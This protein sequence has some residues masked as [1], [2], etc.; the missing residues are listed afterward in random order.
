MSKNCVCHP[1]ILTFAI[2]LHFTFNEGRYTDILLPGT[3]L[4]KDHIAVEYLNS[5]DFQIWTC[6]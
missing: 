2:I 4:L 5:T 6:Q 1:N 3:N